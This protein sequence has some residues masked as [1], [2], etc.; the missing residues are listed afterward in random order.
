MSLLFIL[1]NFFVDNINL[2]VSDITERVRKSRQL[3]YFCGEKSF[4]MKL[5]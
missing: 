4:M 3:S 2:E 1:L 5:T